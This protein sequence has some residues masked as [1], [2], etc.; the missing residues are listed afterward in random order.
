LSYTSDGHFTPPSSPKQLDD[1]VESPFKHQNPNNLAF[2]MC[3]LPTTFQMDDENNEF[4]L[5]EKCKAKEDPIWA[6]RFH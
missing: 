1:E 4:L 2:E 5:K 6:R 3:K